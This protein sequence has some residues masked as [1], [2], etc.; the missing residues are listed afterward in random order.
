[1]YSQLAETA[2]HNVTPAIP[3]MDAVMYCLGALEKFEKMPLEQV[4]QIGFEIALLGTRGID[5][6]NPESHYTLKSLPGGTFSGLHLLSLQ[7]VAFKQIAPDQNI[8]FDLS[9]EYQ[10]ALKLFGNKGK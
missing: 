10:A 6:N 1:V 5:V 3:R 9:T 4:R 2:F 8:G 7:F